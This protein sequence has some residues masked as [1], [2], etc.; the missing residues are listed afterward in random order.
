MNQTTEGNPK[1]AAD[2]KEVRAAQRAKDLV[3]INHFWHSNQS[4]RHPSVTKAA[5]MK[6]LAYRWDITEAM[7]K[8]PIPYT[9]EW[10]KYAAK[11]EVC[12]STWRWRV[13]KKGMTP[14]EAA[15]TP[16]RGS[17]C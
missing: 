15:L 7:T 2:T 4:I 11:S 1:Q 13:A 5:F 12:Y 17:P 9:K 3:V 6:R 10:R 8:A 16:R 14:K